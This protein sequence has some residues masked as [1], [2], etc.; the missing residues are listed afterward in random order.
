MEYMNLAK[1]KDYQ[2]SYLPEK[3]KMNIAKDGIRYAF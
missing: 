1:S 2:I 3:K